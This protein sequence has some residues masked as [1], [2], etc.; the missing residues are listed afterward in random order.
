MIAGLTQQQINVIIGEVLNIPEIE[1]VAV[2]GSRAMG[3]QKPGSDVDLAIWGKNI[4]HSQA[5]ALSIRLNQYTNLPYK[6]DVV[7]FDRITEPELKKHIEEFGM[8]IYNSTV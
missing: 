6:F 4:D 1:R 5:I 3:N 2:F 8:V 7:T